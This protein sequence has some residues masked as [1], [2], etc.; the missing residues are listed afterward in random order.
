[1]FGRR[2][3]YARRTKENPGEERRVA[4]NPDYTIN[5]ISVDRAEPRIK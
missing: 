3:V 1:M 4:Q 2:S 5:R